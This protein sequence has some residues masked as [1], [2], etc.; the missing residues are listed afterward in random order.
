MRIEVE[1]GDSAGELGSLMEWLVGVDEL[2]GAV[3]PVHA[4]PPE[5]A[6][7]PV[8]EA[9]DVLV[10]PGGVAAAGA[11][12]LVAW[13]RHR[14]GSVRVR[15]RKPDGTTVTLDAEKVRGLSA[16]DVHAQVEQLLRAVEEPA[17]DDARDGDEREP[18]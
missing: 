10:G 9:L 6:L 13:L 17:A 12:S 8:L 11:T 7:G 4:P 2:R 16:D 15:V 18:S 1:E 3:R 5:G 14:A